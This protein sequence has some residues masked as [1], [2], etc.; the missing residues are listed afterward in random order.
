[1]RTLTEK[2]IKVYLAL[3]S[4]PHTITLS[5]FAKRLGWTTQEVLDVICPVAREN[6]ENS[7]QHILSIMQQ[8]DEALEQHFLEPMVDLALLIQ[9]RLFELK[10]RIKPT[11]QEYIRY[12]EKWKQYRGY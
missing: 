9:D 10:R 11:N 2:E 7:N 1:M 5:G 6:R 4:E 12:L 3:R 8:G